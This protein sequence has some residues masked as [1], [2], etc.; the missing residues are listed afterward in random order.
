MQRK[1]LPAPSYILVEPNYRT[2]VRRLSCLT[3]P[4]CSQ[5]T[6]HGHRKA[7]RHSQHPHLALPSQS[8]PFAPSCSDP[9]SH[10]VYGPYVLFP[11]ITALVWL[12]GLLALLGLWVQ[13]GKPRYQSD[14]AMVVFISDVAAAHKVSRASSYSGS[15]KSTIRHSSSSSLA[16]LRRSTSSRYL[17]NGGCVMSIGCPPI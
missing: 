3:P 9:R 10:T 15:G 8:V 4:S 5:P 11:L 14:E 17:R 12:A 6:H 7:S 2:S 13:S 1:F 16:S